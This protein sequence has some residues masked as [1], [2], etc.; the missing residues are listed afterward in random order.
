M[1]KKFNTNKFNIH[2]KHDYLELGSRRRLNTN[3]RDDLLSQFEEISYHSSQPMS[4]MLDVLLID[5][6]ESEDTV[7]SFIK[8]VRRY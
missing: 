6:L 7:K 3:I 2:S 1:K 4:K 5:L 8:K